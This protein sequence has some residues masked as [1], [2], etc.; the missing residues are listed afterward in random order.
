MDKM[1]PA[2]R[3]ARWPKWK[4]EASE[5]WMRQLKEDARIIRERMEYC[6]KYGDQ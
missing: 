1:T 2:E 5:E 6:R 3:V 4:Q